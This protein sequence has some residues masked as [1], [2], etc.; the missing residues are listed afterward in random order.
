V[1]KRTV[2]R[3]NPLFT[4]TVTAGRN[5]HTESSDGLI[6]ADLPKEMGGPGKP[7]TATPKHLFAAGH[8]AC[9]GSVVLAS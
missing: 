9:F 6:R 8:A 2:D 7:G 1:R 5:G 4:A 3:I